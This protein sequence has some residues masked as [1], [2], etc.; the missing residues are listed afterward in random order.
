MALL[1]VRSHFSEML[2]YNGNRSAKNVLD[3]FLH[4]VLDMLLRAAAD[5]KETM[6]SVVFK[7]GKPI[8]RVVMEQTG[9]AKLTRFESLVF[10]IRVA[11]QFT[12]A[13]LGERDNDTR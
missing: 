1:F 12:K 6:N 4:D 7:L 9:S 13:F 5:H 11:E 2:E 10:G 3:F 8:L